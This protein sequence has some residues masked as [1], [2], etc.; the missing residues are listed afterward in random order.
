MFHKNVI[1]IDQ[2]KNRRL[3]DLNTCK[4]FSFEHTLI[5]AAQEHVLGIGQLLGLWNIDQKIADK[6]KKRKK[7][8]S[9]PPFTNPCN[10]LLTTSCISLWF[11]HSTLLRDTTF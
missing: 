7:L 6:N 2:H 5:T 10:A 9:K 4:T 11:Q 1:N 8:S 3:V